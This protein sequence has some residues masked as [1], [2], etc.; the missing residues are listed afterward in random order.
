MQPTTC[1][2]FATLP[3]KTFDNDGAGLI[4]PALDYLACSRLGQPSQPLSAQRSHPERSI[5]VP[6]RASRQRI[7]ARRVLP[8][9]IYVAVWRQTND[10]AIADRLGADRGGKALDDFAEKGLPRQLI[11]QWY[12]L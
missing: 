5:C 8:N 2:A 6:H 10:E 11:G 3:S 9:Q 12:A 1:S 7:V 4:R